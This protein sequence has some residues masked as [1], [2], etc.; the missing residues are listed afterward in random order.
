MR[1]WDVWVCTRDPA[2]REALVDH[3]APWVRML[4]ARSYRH[5]VSMELEFAD[6]LQF[7][8]I[9][10]L[11]A[12]DR[13]DHTQGVA[14]ESY[15]S[16][17][18]NGAI[19][20]GV[21]SLSERQRQVCT[22]QRLRAERARSLVD[23]HSSPPTPDPLQRLADLA[24]GLAMGFM[25][26]DTGVYQPDEAV[27]DPAPTPYQRLELAQLRERVA[28]LVDQLP[29]AERRVIRQHYYH[30]LPFEQIATACSLTKGRISQI[31]H[32][33][34]KRLRQLCAEADRVV[35]VT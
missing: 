27:A 33:A 8:M 25:L 34:L 2:A 15:A 23:G 14:F 26:E 20:N 1:L 28:R 31:H 18:V 22:R 29:T 9:G 10:L 13:F 30:H 32:A 19:L 5:R 4:A 6:Y 7:A 24:V 21:E 11:E 16:R 3:Y 12:I 35:L 17:R